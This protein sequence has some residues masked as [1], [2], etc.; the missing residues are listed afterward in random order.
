MWLAIFKETKLIENFW[1]K[2]GSVGIFCGLQFTLSQMH[3]VNQ[4]FFLGLLLTSAP[5]GARHT[6]VRS[7]K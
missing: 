3:G 4:Y 5:R 6:A 1:T 7:M 2:Y